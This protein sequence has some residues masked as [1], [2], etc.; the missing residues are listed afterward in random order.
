MERTCVR[1]K[2]GDCQLEITWA[3][4]MSN[5]DEGDTDSMRGSFQMQVIQRY[6][7]V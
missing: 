3:A 5:E 1:M 6:H 4:A 7:T 2:M